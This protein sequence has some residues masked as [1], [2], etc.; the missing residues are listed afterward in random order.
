[1]RR[2]P[3][4]LL[5]LALAACGGKGTSVTINAHSEDGDNS[6]FAMNNGTVAIKGDG[7]EGSFKV[8]QIKMT[9][10]NFD[11]DGV[12]LYPGSTITSFNIDAQDHPGKAKDEG[13]VTADFTSPA[14][15]ATVQGW[16]RDKLTAKGFK[17][18]AQG[19][20]FAGTT[21]DGETFT[22]GLSGDG[23]A[24]TKGRMEIVGS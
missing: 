14:A 23:G 21:A 9:A 5:P 17:F 24:R 15:L 16:F 22:I 1:M 20:G 2:L 18:A 10:E 19:D 3:L 7:F 13:K 8:P 4:L 11:M 12:K 6:T